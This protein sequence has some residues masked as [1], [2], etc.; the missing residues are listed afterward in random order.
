MTIKQKKRIH[1]KIMKKN[2]GKQMQHTMK[3]NTLV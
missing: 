3:M 2:Q 1:Q